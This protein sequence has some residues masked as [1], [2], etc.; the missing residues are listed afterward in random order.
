MDCD[1]RVTDLSATTIL[2]ASPDAILLVDDAGRITHANDRV[3]D[4]FG[5]EPDE[6]I[7]DEIERLV[8]EDVREAHVADRDAYFDSPET[9]PMGASLELA[10]RHRDGSTVPVDVSLSPVVLDG[11]TFAIAVVR[12]VSQQAALQTKF[13]TI[14]DAVPDAVVVADATTGEIIEV[15]QQAA[16]FFDYDPDEL[17]GRDQSTLHPDDD[18]YEQLFETHVTA[19]RDIFSQFP[20]GSPLYVETSGGTQVP[21]EINAYVFELDSRRLIAGVFR[22]ITARKEREG[23]LEQLHTAT[24]DLMRATSTKEVAEIATK[25]ASQVLD[26]PMNGVHRYDEEADALVPV[27]WTGESETVFDGPPPTIPAGDGLAWRVYQTGTPEAYSDLAETDDV[28]NAET[29][30]RSELFLPLGDHGLLLV[31]STAPDAFDATDEALARVL[32]ANVE[33]ALDRVEREEAL[34]R[35]NERLDEFASIVSHDLRNPLNVAKGRLALARDAADAHEHLDDVE[36][37]HDRMESL[38]EDLLTVAREGDPATDVQVVGLADA[39][40]ACWGHV[41]TPDA[42]LAVETER[43]VRAD[44]GRV[45]QLLENLF[46]NA[47]EHGGEAVTIT[48]GDLAG[49]FYVADDGPGLPED[50]TDPFEAG[51][52]TNADGTG[53]GLFIVEQ[54]ADAHGW[55][56]SVTEGSEGGAR[57]EFRAVDVED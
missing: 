3:T 50:G 13:R 10:G 35:Q 33:S 5:Y 45:R 12:D 15:S 4:L 34:K 48:V 30:F 19:G 11:E 42:T 38:I 29:P 26:L 54:V 7:G 27:A 44:P 52:S 53:L 23:A 22:D 32:A 25:T 39:A 18:R 14:L 46:R 47:I 56:V 21:V 43:T 9:R 41:R 2:D 31:S 1:R 17:V 36:R 16:D 24:R 8:P 40:E 28:L 37:A 51:Y 6:L 20:D 55:D 49:G 57:F